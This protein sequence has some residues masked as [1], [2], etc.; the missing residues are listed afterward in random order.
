MAGREAG[1]AGH[2]LDDARP[3]QRMQLDHLPLVRIEGPGLEQYAIGDAELAHIA[4]KA[5]EH[6]VLARPGIEIESPSHP[7]HACR[8]LIRV[9][10]H[11]WVLGLDGVGEHAH[12]REVGGAHL[13]MELVVLEHRA[14]VVAQREQN[15]VVEVLEAALAVGADDHALEVVEHVDR[16]GHEVL[17]LVVGR[18]I[19][20]AG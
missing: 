11:E 1:E 17:D 4:Q 9:R 15:V 19:A 3:D 14:G 16:D 13:A 20:L 18:R 8:Y 7:L 2:A 10:P 5:G 6:E 12:D